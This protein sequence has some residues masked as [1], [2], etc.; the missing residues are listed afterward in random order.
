MAWLCAHVGRDHHEDRRLAISKLDVAEARTWRT[1]P[2]AGHHAPSVDVRLAQSLRAH[3][4]ICKWRCCP[5][6]LSAVALEL[7]LLLLL[8]LQLQLQ[9]VLVYAA[10]CVELSEQEQ[11]ACQDQARQENLQHVHRDAALIREGASQPTLLY[12]WGHTHSQSSNSLGN[13]PGNKHTCRG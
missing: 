12:S 10:G 13:K 8:L 4:C 3:V 5:S 9:L 7:L 2:P 6:L 11:H 1:L